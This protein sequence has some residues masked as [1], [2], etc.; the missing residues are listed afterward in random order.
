MTSSPA[1]S[2]TP[3]VAVSAGQARVTSCVL[4]CVAAAMLYLA[5]PRLTA[6]VAVAPHGTTLA[7]LDKTPSPNAA[8]QDRAAQAHR[9]ALAWRDDPQS[10]AALGAL[11][12]AAAA[13]AAAAGDPALA[14]EALAR[15]AAEHRAA[16]AMAPL[17]PYVW[18]RLVQDELAAAG[19]SAEAAGHMRMA[20][21]TAPWEP[22]LMTARLGLAF[23][24]WE[25]FDDAMRD[26]LGGQIRHAARL[27]STSLA[28]QA[29]A[30]RAQDHVLQALD[31]DPDLLRR[32]SLAYSRI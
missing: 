21:D 9:R 16:L 4:L 12:L 18:T 17:Q 2:S 6:G 32:F 15:S 25:H 10:H 8:A 28:R 29:R 3:I 11:A 5:V 22:A 24:L 1:A 7:A 13:R 27:Y 23:V 31:D 26:R 19:A 30:Y 14:R 20:I